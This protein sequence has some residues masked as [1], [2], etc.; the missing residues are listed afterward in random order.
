MICITNFTPVVRHNHRIGVPQ[1]GD[2]H[3][4]LSTDAETYGGSGIG[5][6]VTT[7]EPVASHNRPQSLQ[8]TLPALATLILEPVPP[9][10][11]D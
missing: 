9:A 7:A 1:A 10:T 3:E 8:L 11:G 5:N 2:Y 4:L 6:P